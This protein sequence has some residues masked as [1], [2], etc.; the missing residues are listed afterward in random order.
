MNQSGPPQ[1]QPGY[2]GSPLLGLFASLAQMPQ[3]A[4][5]KQ[6]QQWKFDQDRVTYGKQA[7]DQLMQQGIADPKLRADPNYQS[8][9]I[10]IGKKFGMPIPM[11]QGPNGAMVDFDALQ[12]PRPMAGMTNEQREYLQ[13]MPT[14]VRIKT[15][16]TMFSDV[17]P[18]DPFFKLDPFVPLNAGRAT[19]IENDLTKNLDAL[20]KA[21]M[22]PQDFQKWVRDNYADLKLMKHDPDQYLSDDFAQHSSGLMAQ[23]IMD[24]AAALNIHWKNED[25][26]RQQLADQSLQEF[27]ERDATTRYGIDKR[28][29]EAA[30]R[31]TEAQEGLELRAQSLEIQRGKLNDMLNN[32]ALRTN[33]WLQSSYMKE[34]SNLTSTYT[35]LQSDLDTVNNNIANAQANH[36]PVSKLATMMEEQIKLKQQLATMA[37]DVQAAQNNAAEMQTWAVQNAIGHRIS[38]PGQQTGGGIGFTPGKKGGAVPGATGYTFTGDTVKAD[39]GSTIYVVTDAHGKKTGWTPGE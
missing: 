20:G 14:D 3:M 4:M 1:D 30:A 34:A 11:T 13:Q 36:V 37:P 9:F 35:K 32:T 28:A 22:S 2:G 5:N 12:A 31:I 19:A 21:A 6:E 24:K 26:V 39:D 7:L 38:L 18:D 15:A 16:Q 8:Q 29:D 27:K 17:N 33:M 25:A 10:Q 23:S